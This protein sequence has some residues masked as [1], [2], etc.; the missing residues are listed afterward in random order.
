MSFQSLMS[1]TLAVT[2]IDKTP[3]KTLEVQDQ[4]ADQ[5]TVASSISR[6]QKRT[7]KTKTDVWDHLQKLKKRAEVWPIN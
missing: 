7:Y 1:W 4:S 3:K 5:V 2:G 6:K